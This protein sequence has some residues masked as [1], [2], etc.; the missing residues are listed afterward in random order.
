MPERLVVGR[1]DVKDGGYSDPR[2]FVSWQV[3]PAAIT[4]FGS[5]TQR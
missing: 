1:A 4:I 3:T 5:P 2:Q